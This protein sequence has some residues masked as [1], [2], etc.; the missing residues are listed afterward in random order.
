MVTT[1]MAITAIMETMTMTMT[2]ITIKETMVM[3]METMTMT[4]ITIKETMIMITR[5]MET[6]QSRFNRAGSTAAVLTRR[7]VRQELKHLASITRRRAN[8]VTWV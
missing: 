8:S 5:I 4:M 6:I 7:S 1:T 3:I 2:T